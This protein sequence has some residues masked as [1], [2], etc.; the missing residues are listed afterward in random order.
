M[1][2]TDPNT[3]DTIANHPDFID[4]PFDPRWYD[5]DHEADLKLL[6]DLAVKLKQRFYQCETR[7]IVL[8]DCTTYIEVESANLPKFCV[9]PSRLDSGEGGLYLDIEGDS[10]ELYLA[11]IESVLQEISE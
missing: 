6:R 7:L 1:N 5:G 10:R 2:I 8:D 4:K 11:S 3:W 9:H